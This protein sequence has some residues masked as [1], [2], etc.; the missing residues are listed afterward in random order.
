[1][2]SHCETQLISLLNQQKGPCLW[3]ADEGTLLALIKQ[4]QA[5]PEIEVISNRYDIVQQFQQQGFNTYLNDFEF[6]SLPADHYQTII[7]PICKERS[8][9]NHC[10]NSAFR[11]LKTDGCLMLIGEKHQGI[12]T[13]CKNAGKA[14]GSESNFKKI[15]LCYQGTIYKQSDQPDLKLD[16]KNYP[17]LQQIDA[18]AISFRSK[19]GV[20]G[21]NKIDQGSAFLIETCRKQL[22][23]RDWKPESLLDLGCGYGYLT[24]MTRDLD[25]P[26]RYATD[27]NAAA[28]NAAQ[29]N[30]SEYNMDVSCTLDDCGSNLNER[31]ELILC[32]PP[33]HR[34]FKTNSDLTKNFLQQGQRLLHAKG[35]ALWVLNKFIDVETPALEH[36]K[37]LDVL[38]ENSQFKVIRLRK[39]IR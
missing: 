15:G 9:A 7:F 14:F 24:L 10:I 4:V 36:F 16:D 30:F 11:L 6:D 19:P 21:W 18:E 28:I 3:I 33:F 27:N 17:E 12:K 5:R 13:H 29:A 34:G 35:M 31:C 32:N 22:A 25:I 38:D 8:L 1:M 39:P 26:N 23:Q 20:F 37:Q 2:N